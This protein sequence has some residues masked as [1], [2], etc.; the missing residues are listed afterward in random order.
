MGPGMSTPGWL[1]RHAVVLGTAVAVLA[2]LAAVVTVVGVGHR[3]AT[4]DRRVQD[5]ATTLKCPS[6]NGETVAASNAPIAQS[7]RVEIRHQLGQGRT[8]DQIRSWFEARYGTAVV[9][10][11]PS[12]GP[13]VLLWVLPGLVLCG[14]AALAIGLVR[15]RGRAGGRPS[16]ASALPGKRVAVAAGACLAVGALVPAVVWARAGGGQAGQ[17]AD[18]AASATATPSADRP[19]TADDWS[20][21]GTS[22]E[23]QHDYAGAARAYRRAVHLRPASGALRIR[24]GFD[25]LR[26]GRA[27][28]A[29][30]VVRPL[31]RHPGSERPMALLVLGLAQRSRH[32]PAASHTLRTF[33]KVAPNHPAA[34]QVRRLLAQD[35]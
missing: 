32:D 20:Q 1:R 8:P 30:P 16:T 13:E 3:P 25:L 15:R 22:L 12:G 17:V 35:G 14:G 10:L 9:T 2:V 7:M 28:D 5:V 11:P 31:S 24:L 29:V 4:M 23:S 19:L 33:L 26:A 21:V 6:C 34:A 18:A 27:G